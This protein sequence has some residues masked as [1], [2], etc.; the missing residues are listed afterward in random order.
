MCISKFLIIFHYI[1]LCLT[2]LYQALCVDAI[3][4]AQTSFTLI[5]WS[6]WELKHFLSFTVYYNTYYCERR[7]HFQEFSNFAFVLFFTLR[8]F[9]TT[10]ADA[11]IWRR[12]FAIFVYRFFLLSFVSLLLNVIKF[13]GQM[14][15]G[16]NSKGFL[17][18]RKHKM[19][20]FKVK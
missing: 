1:H 18:I 11:I 13:H 6:W 9:V 7:N 17:K 14:E 10:V 20:L 4:E 5:F 19:V 16:L 15:L 2:M 3:A 12:L 8:Y